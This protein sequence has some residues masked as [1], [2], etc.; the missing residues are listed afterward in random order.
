MSTCNT[1]GDVLVKAL[2]AVSQSSTLMYIDHNFDPMQF[3]H[4]GIVQL[5]S[6]HVEK[7]LAGLVL[8]LAEGATHVVMQTEW[9]LT[10]PIPMVQSWGLTKE[11]TKCEWYMVRFQILEDMLLVFQRRVSICLYMFLSHCACSAKNATIWR[12]WQTNIKGIFEWKPGQ[13]RDLLVL[14]T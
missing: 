14:M 8:N 7:Q 10:S 1:N 2:L 9:V 11:R 5:V 3:G 6:V 4:W 12:A 13:L